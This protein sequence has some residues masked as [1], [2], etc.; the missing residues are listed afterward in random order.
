MVAKIFDITRST[1]K[2]LVSFYFFSMKRKKRSSPHKIVSKNYFERWTRQGGSI[3]KDLDTLRSN[4]T[5]LQKLSFDF[6][7]RRKQ[8]PTRYNFFEKIITNFP[9]IRVSIILIFEFISIEARPIYNFDRSNSRRP[10]GRR[11]RLGINQP[12]KRSAAVCR[13]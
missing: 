7:P 13:K 2:L 8:Y 5:P 9:S 11:T 10:S 6:Q 3:P 1:Q 4:F 12:V